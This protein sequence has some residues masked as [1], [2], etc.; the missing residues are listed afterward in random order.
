M[1]AFIVGL[2]GGIGSGKTVCSDH[3]HTIGVPIIDTD[4]IAR[5]IVQPGQ[6]AL[7]ELSKAFGEKILL[8][9]GHLDRATLRDIAFSSSSNKAK[10]DAITHPAIRRA[11]I[12][13]I[14]EVNYPYCIV[15]I[16]LLTSDSAFN[17]LL[18]RIL[19]VTADRETKIERVK[20][21]SQLDREEVLR[22]MKTQLDDSTRLDFA[23]DVVSN[24]GT[25]KDAQ[26]AV[27][28][29]HQRY[30]DL[31]LSTPHLS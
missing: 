20:T 5:E 22:I 11:T 31:A 19:V 2:T 8:A 23:D 7:S 24:D 15:V 9:D 29:L 21:R 26:L 14:S 16:P 18:D 17:E 4:V 30:L 6:R 25:I 1:S 13:Q 3:F 27:D 28:E 10:L 12:E